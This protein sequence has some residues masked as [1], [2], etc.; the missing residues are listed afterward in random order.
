MCSAAPSQ[1]E[2]SPW[3]DVHPGGVLPWGESGRLGLQLDLLRLLALL[4]SLPVAP[5]LRPPTSQ[6]LTHLQSCWH[7]DRFTIYD[8]LLQQKQ[9]PGGAECV[10]GGGGGCTMMSTL[11]VFSSHACIVLTCSS[12]SSRMLTNT[13][14]SELHAAGTAM[15]SCRQQAGDTGTLAANVF[16]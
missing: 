2:P 9:P 8:I 12:S 10:F 4:L 15:S 16:R 11:I 6:P 1:R 14:N 5:A 3:H 13:S 7:Q